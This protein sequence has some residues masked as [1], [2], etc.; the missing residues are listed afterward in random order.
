MILREGDDE[1][2]ATLPTRVTAAPNRS[3]PEERSFVEPRLAHLLG[4]AEVTTR[5]PGSLRGLANVLRAARTERTDGSGLRGPALGGQQ[6]ARL[7]G[8]PARVVARLSDLR[9]HSRP[10]GAAG[11]APELGSRPTQPHLAVPGAAL[12]VGDGRAARRPGSGV[13]GGL[14]HP[15]PGACR[16]RAGWR[17][18]LRTSRPAYRL[19][20]LLGLPARRR[21]L[22]DGGDHGQLHLSGCGSLVGTIARCLGCWA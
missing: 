3:L 13:A 6:S 2:V 17:R 7:R 4:L 16:G 22:R 5:S 14:A 11:A 21:G 20:D 8:I 18:R 10:A 1:E 12:T 9:A 15:D 19:L